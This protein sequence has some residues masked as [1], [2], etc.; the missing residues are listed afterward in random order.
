MLFILAGSNCVLQ[1]L[2]AK[3]PPESAV[4]LMNTIVDSLLDASSQW[5]HKIGEGLTYKVNISTE[6]NLA[7]VCTNTCNL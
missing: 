2:T 6:E 1:I 3:P 4:Q 5:S 7:V